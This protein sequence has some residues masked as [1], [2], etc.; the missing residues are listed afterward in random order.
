MKKHIYSMLA[1]VTISGAIGVNAQAEEVVVEK[2]DTLWAL[3][4]K[5]EIAVSDIKEW[6][7]L[8]ND[9]IRPDDVLTVSPV[10]NYIVKSGDTLWEIAKDQKVN[11]DD[12]LKWNN[13]S[14]D[15]IHPDA[16]LVIYSNKQ[17]AV[18]AAQVVAAAAPAEQPAR[19]EVAVNPA[20]APA[21]TKPEPTPA[22]PESNAKELTVTATAYTASCEG[23]SGVTATGIDLNAN[24][25]A[26]VISVDPN[27]IPLGSKVYVEGY[28]YAVAGDTGGAI[29]GNVIDIFIP[30]KQEAVNWGRKQVK[31]QILD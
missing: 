16:N 13:L 18:P 31:V 7:A 3:A 14:S 30:D 24:P 21:Q 10:K 26:K 22:E 17:A 15:M 19:A 12:L 8:S 23:C 20:P 9:L 25:D 1:A 11:V 29:K 4:Q 5:Y 28:G 27:V 2:G 6:N